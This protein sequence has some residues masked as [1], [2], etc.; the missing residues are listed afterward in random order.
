[1]TNTHSRFLLAAAASL[2]AGGTALAAQTRDPAEIFAMLD[3][4]RDDVV[5]LAEFL[6][7]P[8]FGRVANPGDVLAR[9]QASFE[10]IDANRDG[11]L[12]LEE[13]K[14]LPLFNR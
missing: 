5:S 3:K 6:A 7:A 8:K 12:T 14:A 11:K 2:L 9:R 10:R 1:M 4:N 13:F